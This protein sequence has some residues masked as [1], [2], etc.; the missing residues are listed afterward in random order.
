MMEIEVPQGLYTTIMGNNPSKFKGDNLPVENVSWYDAI[1]FCNSLSKKYNYKPVYNMSITGKGVVVTRD[2]SADGFRLPTDEEWEFAARGGESYK[3]A[4]SNNIDE[5][6]WYHLNSGGHTHW[7]GQKKPNGYGLYDMSGNVHEW[8][9][10]S[11]LSD[12]FRNLRGG[13]W[14][15]NED[16]CK[17]NNYT[18]ALPEWNGFNATNDYGIFGFRVVQNIK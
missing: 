16:S 17:I 11:N 3:Y 14:R 18:F 10:C 13:S 7:V 4:G 15:F 8:C 1:I 2:F 9:D 5:V 6:A 12:Y